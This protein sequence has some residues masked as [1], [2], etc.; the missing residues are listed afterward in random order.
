[1][2]ATATTPPRRGQP[3]RDD[4]KKGNAGKKTESNTASKGNDT[5]RPSKEATPRKQRPVKSEPNGGSTSAAA[6][7]PTMT[8]QHA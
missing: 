2:A 8:R 7:T 5:N 3:P 1:M 6:A 4:K